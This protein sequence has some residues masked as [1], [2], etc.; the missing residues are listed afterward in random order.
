MSVVHAVI[1]CKTDSYP[2]LNL[3]WMKRQQTMSAAMSASPALAAR[4]SVP[5][6]DEAPAIPGHAPWLAELYLVS[7]EYNPTNVSVYHTI[8]GNTC[9]DG[10]HFHFHGKTHVFKYNPN[11]IHTD[12]KLL[13]NAIMSLVR[14]LKTYYREASKNTMVREAV[15]HG[16]IRQSD[17]NAG[18]SHLCSVLARLPASSATSVGHGIDCIMK[19]PS[20]RENVKV[21]VHR[22]ITDLKLRIE[23]TE[24]TLGVDKKKKL[25]TLSKPQQNYSGNAFYTIAVKTSKPVVDSAKSK[26]KNGSAQVEYC[27]RG[28][29]EG[30]DENHTK[31]TPTRRP[32]KIKRH[33][34]A[35]V[36]LNQNECNNNG[37]E[38]FHPPRIKSAMSVDTVDENYTPVNPNDTRL[39]LPGDNN[40]RMLLSQGTNVM[41]AW[42]EV[43]IAPVPADGNSE[44]DKVRHASDDPVG[45]D[46]YVSDNEY[47]QIF[48][49]HPLNNFGLLFFSFHTTG[50]AGW[51]GVWCC[52]TR[53]IA[54]RRA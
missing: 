35:L 50:R 21:L 44:Q 40:S 34:F 30:Q 41:E 38:S 17:F 6:L 45:R 1:G 36:S 13:Y 22:W 20:A 54:K 43:E 48:D 2:L 29:D 32:K 46:F 37:N 3:L 16:L 28:R 7:G 53:C 47:L 5:S 19:A 15:T 31:K 42:A 23:I 49:A 9:L 33:C 52:S 12:I 51:K 26:L 24:P 27:R 8:V 39:S 4:V 18:W 14:S 25:K 10:Y 11:P